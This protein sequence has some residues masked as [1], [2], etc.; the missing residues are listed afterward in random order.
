MNPSRQP[1]VDLY[2]IPLGAGGHSVRFNGRVFEAICAATEHRRRYDLYHSALVIELD[3]ARYTI[4]VAPSPDANEASRGVVCTGAVGSRHLRWLRV[5]RY[6]V[7]CW[8]GGSIPDLN[9]AVG[10]GQ[11]LTG[12]SAVARRLLQVV[13][14]VPTPVWGRDELKTGDMWNSNSVI[15]WA[16]ANAGLS[17][18]SLRPPAGGRAPGWDA[19]LAV[20]RRTGAVRSEAVTDVGLARSAGRSAIP[21]RDA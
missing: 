11:R 7:R 20:A 10:A 21:S 16:I 8:R 2:W 3:D 13:A 19:G 1:S 17:A 12:D 6:E 14:D 18:A 15:A 9:E 4:E 5:F